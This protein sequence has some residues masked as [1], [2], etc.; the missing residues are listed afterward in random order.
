MD[1]SDHDLDRKGLLLYSYGVIR[2]RTLLK[3]DVNMEIQV[4][5]T[6]ILVSSLLR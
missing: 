4:H 5:T 2:I 6:C 1:V 3:R